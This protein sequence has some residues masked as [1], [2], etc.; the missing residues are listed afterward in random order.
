M[1]PETSPARV[2]ESRAPVPT[3]IASSLGGVGGVNGGVV[4]TGLGINPL[5]MR[6]PYQ[7]PGKS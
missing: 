6:N 2:G 5:L 3:S 4:G 1:T 7:S